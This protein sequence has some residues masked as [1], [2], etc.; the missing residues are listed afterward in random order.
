[1]S[2]SLCSTSETNIMLYINHTLLKNNNMHK[3]RGQR[4]PANQPHRAEMQTVEGRFRRTVKVG[5]Q[6]FKFV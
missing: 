2:E 3:A 1:M 6:S 5:S 4:V